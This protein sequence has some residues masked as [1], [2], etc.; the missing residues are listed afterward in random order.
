MELHIPARARVPA[1]PID[2]SCAWLGRN[3]GIRGEEV[4]RASFAGGPC[5]YWVGDRG[6]AGN[7]IRRRRGPHAPA[8]RPDVGRGGRPR[9]ARVRRGGGSGRRGAGGGA[10]S[11]PGRDRADGPA[12]GPLVA[13]LGPVPHQ[14]RRGRAAQRAALAAV[15]R[16][17]PGL[18][19]R[20]GHGRRARRA[21]GGAAHHRGGG[22]RGRRRG[23]RR[24]GR[25]ARRGCRLPRDPG[26]ALPGARQPDG[27]HRGPQRP[28]SP[29]RVDPPA[30]RHAPPRRARGEHRCGARPAGAQRPRRGVPGGAAPAWWMGRAGGVSALRDHRRGPGDDRGAGR[31]DQRSVRLLHARDRGGARG[32][33]RSG[34]RGGWTGPA[35]GP[36]GGG[37][38]GGCRRHPAGA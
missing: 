23:R 28:S 13:A 24:P 8:A 1:A 34:A 11:G 5:P 18:G 30:A 15:R 27:D 2:G 37:C 16:R 25:T 10:G 20:P 32:R 6:R 4:A 21:H 31:A 26:R 22:R 35:R 14:H 9:A 3:G 12:A 7:G 19:G 38:A 17:H 33:R 29:P 36:G